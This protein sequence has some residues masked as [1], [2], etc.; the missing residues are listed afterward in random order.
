MEI[1]TTKEKAPAVIG[2]QARA[3]KVQDDFN[4]S[5]C[6]ADDAVELAFKRGEWLTDWDAH[7]RFGC[8]RFR[9]LMSELRNDGWLFHDEWVSGKN[10]YG[11]DAKWKRYKLIKAGA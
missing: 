4:I 7:K 9:T 6:S 10:R 3:E 8:S 1:K 2:G 11:N 5:P